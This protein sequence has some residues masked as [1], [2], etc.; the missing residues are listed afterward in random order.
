M[1]NIKIIS[2]MLAL[3]FVLQAFTFVVVAEDAVAT[4]NIKAEIP[5][6]ADITGV[7]AYTGATMTTMTAEEAAAEGVSGGSG[8]VIKLEKGSGGSSVTLDLAQI[9]N[10]EIKLA[11]VKSIT[12]P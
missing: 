3:V 9:A 11:D 7:S 6:C 1:K 10:K 12:A 4:D 8:H 5:Y 2:L